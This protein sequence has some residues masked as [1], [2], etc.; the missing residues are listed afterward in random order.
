VTDVR[1][2][3]V[4][5]I[6]VLRQARMLR[7]GIP[8]ILMTAYGTIAAAVEA[9]KLGAVDFITKPFRNEDLV[10]RVQRALEARA[11]HSMGTPAP[12]A[13]SGGSARAP[14]ASSAALRTVMGQVEKIASSRLT[15]LITGETGTGKSMIAQELHRRGPWAGGPFVAINAAALPEPLLESELFGHEKGAFTGATAARA[16][17]FE[18]AEGGTIF[19]DE[20]GALP[21][22]LQS[23][24]LGVL[25]E[26]QV[27]RVGGNRTVSIDAR[28]IAAT[29]TDLEQAVKRGEFRQD[30]YYRLNV[31]R[32]RMPPLREHRED[33]PDLLRELLD[34]LSAGR[35]FR[36]T[37]SAETMGLLTRYPFP[38]NVRELRN[39]IEWAVAVSRSDVIEPADLPE[40]MRLGD[41]DHPDSAAAPGGSLA[42]MERGQIE[43]AVGQLGGNLAEVAR[44]L[45]ISRTTLWR[46]M[47]DYGLKK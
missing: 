25:Q 28:F 10:R 43:R 23:K 13:P 45:G 26:R 17:L 14:V 40:V 15:V 29:N 16:G 21:A 42:E 34:E 2:E 4:S 11:A 12:A 32:I 9:M 22:N 18:A 19:L 31:A 33:I 47:R 30:L 46:K 38:G 35:P 37:I 7:P 39:A 8:V 41:P 3:P 27:R 1:M 20:I 36:Y 24:L 6:D 5:G 44:N